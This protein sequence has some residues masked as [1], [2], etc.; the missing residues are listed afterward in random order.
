MPNAAKRDGGG[1]R[2]AVAFFALAGALIAYYLSLFRM[3][4]LGSLACGTSGGCETVQLSEWS[5]LGGIP[6]PYMA[7]VYYTAIVIAAV[8]GTT[9]RWSG[10]NGL[11]LTTIVLS[12][13]AFG[14]ALYNTA[15]EVFVVHAWCR[16]CLACAACATV[17][18]GLAIAE[19]RAGRPVDAPPSREEAEVELV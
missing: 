16:W 18:A 3:G 13:G 10:N 8:M 7:S 19:L 4:V 6:I 1:R 5:K 11:R 9:G 15:I 12:F 2:K 17:L 14:F